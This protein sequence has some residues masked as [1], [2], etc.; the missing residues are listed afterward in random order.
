[1][2]NKI[3]KLTDFVSINEGLERLSETAMFRDYSNDEMFFQIWTKDCEAI[4]RKLIEMGAN[5]QIVAK[6][7]GWV[8]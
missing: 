3:K 8:N 2:K 5:K 6:A 1:M 7:A 4:A